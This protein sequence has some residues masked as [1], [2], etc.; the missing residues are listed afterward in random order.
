MVETC[1]SKGDCRKDI[2]P[3]LD[4]VGRGVE[5]SNAHQADIRLTMHAQ[6]LQVE[7]AASK[8]LKRRLARQCVGFHSSS[9]ARNSTVYFL[10]K[11][12]LSELSYI[13]FTSLLLILLQYPQLSISLTSY[14][15]CPGTAPTRHRWFS[16]TLFFYILLFMIHHTIPTCPHPI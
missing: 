9:R 4:L 6:P 5:I 7:C 2:R 8:L 11:L 16:P 14:R 13:Y 10:K 12:S 1:L 15:Y 3:Y